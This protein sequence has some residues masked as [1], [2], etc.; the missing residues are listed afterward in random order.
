MIE[1]NKYF[2]VEINEE[3]NRLMMNAFGLLIHEKEKGVSGYYNLPCDSLNLLKEAKDYM[4]NED[5]VYQNAKY[6]VVIGI[7]GSSLGTKA[8]NSML[9]HKYKNI[10][11]MIFLENP[12]PVSLSCNLSKVKKENSIFI[13]VSKSGGTVETISN[14]KM[15]LNRYQFDLK[16]IKDNKRIIIITDEGS[17]L[18]KFA[19]AYKIKTFTI[20]SNV[21]GRFSVLSAVGVIPLSLAGYDVQDI[22]KGADSFI[23]S[24]FDAKEEHIIL[25]AL[26][27][28]QNYKKYPINVL[29]SYADFL[30]DFTKWF[31]QL[32]AESLG[33]IDK[34]DDSVGL[35]PIAHIGAVDQHSF[36]Q[37]IMQGVK[38]K[39]VTFI[40]IKDFENN[41]TI[42]NMSLKYLEKTDFA[43]GVLFNE[44]INAEC[45]ATKESLITKNIP[46][47][48]IEIDKINEE[49]IGQL[50]AYFELLTSCAG[51]LFGI[52]TYNQPGVELGKKILIKKF[53][54][55]N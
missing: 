55:E 2:K 22:L 38:D 9:K 43:N 4:I 18:C 50:I 29:F 45:D 42:P 23:K 13:I 33:K 19:D 8:I 44:L 16:N 32:W 30:E 10:K 20:P 14:F 41:L 15:I 11:E 48:L 21:G 54:K 39:T 51:A 27:Q 1:F 53:K 31:I 5:G 28:V 47:D 40:K 25:K 52:N 17:S 3:N 12:D 6:I 36:L 24:F 26:F 7:G 34:N 37:L 46:V 35:T 49:N